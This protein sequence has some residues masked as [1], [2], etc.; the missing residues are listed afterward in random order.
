MMPLIF[1]S[2]FVP[3]PKRDPIPPLIKEIGD[4]R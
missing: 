1:R 4:V 3:I 2:D